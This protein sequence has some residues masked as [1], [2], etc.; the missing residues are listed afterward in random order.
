ML[1][2]PQYSQ[3]VCPEHFNYLKWSQIHS[4]SNY[5]TKALISYSY[6]NHHDPCCSLQFGGSCSPNCMAFHLYPESSSMVQRVALPHIPVTVF[7]NQSKQ[8]SSTTKQSYITTLG[9]DWLLHLVN[10]GQNQ[11]VK[12]PCPHKCLKLCADRPAC[13]ECSAC[14]TTHTSSK[15]HSLWN[16]TASHTWIMPTIRELCPS[17]IFQ[18]SRSNRNM[19]L[20]K[21]MRYTEYTIWNSNPSCQ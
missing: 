13:A 5:Y 7:Q 19:P 12:L 17:I 16:I 14:G 2:C 21:W 11:R 8:A 15:L 4:V 10:G 9:S 1:P 6:A 18:N 20:P 3:P